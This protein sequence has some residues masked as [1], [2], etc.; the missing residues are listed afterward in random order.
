MKRS[1]LKRTGFKKR[2][3]VDAAQNAQLSQ[4]RKAVLRTGCSLKASRPLRAKRDPLMQAWAR[5]VLTR[6]G[7]RCQWP[8]GC[9]TGDTQIDPHH[10]AERS[11]RPD[12][13]YVVANGKALC[14][15]HHDWL[16]LHRAE[17][18]AMGLLSDE[19]YE[20]AQKEKAAA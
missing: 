16:P 8:A 11:L 4:S 5:E 7:N 10:I 9:S 3:H 6:D 12:L 1:N 15:T 2:V 18:I 19:T 13:R 17:A 14:R 20:K